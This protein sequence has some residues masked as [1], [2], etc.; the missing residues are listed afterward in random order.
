MVMQDDGNLVI[1][2]TTNRPVW[3]SNTYGQGPR[4]HRLVIQHDRNLVIYGNDGKPT[5]ST[6]TDIP[7]WHKIFS[8]GSTDKQLP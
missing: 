6:R 7:W 5:W 2:D 8:P 3:A 4:P 1:Y